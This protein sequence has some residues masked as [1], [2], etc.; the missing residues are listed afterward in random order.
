MRRILVERTR[1]NA[2]VKHGGGRAR[3]ELDKACPV[4]AEPDEDLLALDE[5][6][7]RFSRVAPKKADL[8]KLRFFAG[9]TIPEA[10]EA[11][12][13]SHATAERYWAYARVWL[14]TE[15]NDADEETP[16]D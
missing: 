14:Y 3:V 12:G 7:E 5:A 15:L 8:V 13:I 2:R 4:S 1:R 10:A 9:M 16:D 6:L 11:L